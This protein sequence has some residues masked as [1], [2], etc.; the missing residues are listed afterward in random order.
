MLMWIAH[1]SI[2]NAD[3]SRDD[4]DNCHEFVSTPGSPGTSQHLFSTAVTMRLESLISSSIATET[5]EFWP[6][7][8]HCYHRSSFSLVDC[9]PRYSE[10]IWIL[11]EQLMAIHA[12]VRVT[13]L[14]PYQFVRGDQRS[15][16]LGRPPRNNPSVE[17]AS[18]LHSPI[19]LWRFMLS[20]SRS[21]GR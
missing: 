20:I 17:W 16:Y 5:A 12:L 4:K 15:R 6:E 21:W 2:S 9:H 10:S 11:E 1:A 3:F 18:S 7:L 13:A 19:P 14:I 8:Q